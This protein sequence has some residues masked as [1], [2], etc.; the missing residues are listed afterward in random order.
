MKTLDV[1]YLPK[2]SCMMLTYNRY[3]PL[4]RSVQC[5]IDQTHTNKEL[6][7]INNGDR[8]YFD[9]VERHLKTLTLYPYIKHVWIDNMSL[10]AMRNIGIE[11]A[12]GDYLMVFDDDDVHHPE[13][14]EKQLDLC[15]RSNIDGTVLRNF[16]TVRKRWFRNTI[17]VCSM[18][19]GLD[20][21]ILFRKTDVRYDDMDQ[22]EDTSFLQKLKDEG[23]TI[24]IID[25]DYS[26]YEYWHY[27]HNT[28]SKS[29]FK[30][31]IEQN[32]PLRKR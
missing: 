27:G 16:T 8:E 28:V 20:G 18:L 1:C 7:I 3:I 13:R 12:T 22:G 6:V 10:G 14:I 21:T 23:Y 4:V 25:E 15:M 17:D 26:M 29:H 30:N 11:R 31:M 5:F 19:T 32:T 2:V 9:K 24:T